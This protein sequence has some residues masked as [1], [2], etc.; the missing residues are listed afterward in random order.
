M[1]RGQQG[2]CSGND[3]VTDS[4]WEIDLGGGTADR[5]GFS[6][7]FPLDVPLEV[8]DDWSYDQREVDDAVLRRF[9]SGVMDF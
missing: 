4:E 6:A 7:E 2:V 8:P 9:F 3:P 1:A 5:C